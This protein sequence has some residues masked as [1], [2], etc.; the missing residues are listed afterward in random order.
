MD[1]VREHSIRHSQKLVR[2]RHFWVIVLI[3]AGLI[4][5]YNANYVDFPNWVPWLKE[6]S[7]VEFIH[8]LH[9]SLF[10][11]PL[12][13]AGAMF[14]L[15][16]AVTCWLVFLAAVMPRALYFSPNPGPVVRVLAFALVALLAAI[17]IALEENQRQR[18][19][20]ARDK[21]EIANQIYM[22][23]VLQGQESERQRIAQELHDSV[24]QD[25][26]V[27][28]N[29]LQALTAGE[30]GELPSEVRVQAKDISDMALHA[31]D[32]VRRISHDL[33]PSILDQMGLVASF[34]WLTEHLAEGSGITIDM[35]VSGVERRLSPEA[36]LV[37]FRIAQEALNNT[38]RHS[39]A[40]R[41]VITVDFAPDS[42]RIMVWD[43]GKGFLLPKEMR[44]F[45]IEGKLGLSG[46]QER[47]KL[48]DATLSI[49]SEPGQG[50]TITVEAKV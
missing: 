31:A 36:E 42:L 9:R 21:L 12:L 50:T 49:Q 32:D 45:A 43:N 34:K 26:V 19:R 16:G 15:R 11:I 7:T 8:D 3:M 41:A 38:I 35:M 46:M 28:A 23:K 5:F 14:R 22:T 1:E 27:I 40:N 30:P 24:Q 47:A 6:V 17:L 44:D 25:L 10:L 39:E 2:N 33:R 4:F 20:E 18:E 37:F 48:L 29:R 13:Y